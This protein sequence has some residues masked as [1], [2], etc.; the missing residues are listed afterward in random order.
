[1]GKLGWVAVT[2]ALTG[3]V[4]VNSDTVYGWFKGL[5]DYGKKVLATKPKE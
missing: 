2:A 1:M 3:L 5:S 4:T